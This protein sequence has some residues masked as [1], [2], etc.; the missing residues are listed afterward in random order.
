MAQIKMGILPI[1]QNGHPIII[2]LTI[3]KALF[4]NISLNTR[5]HL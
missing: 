5:F 1:R 4:G 2:N 3:H